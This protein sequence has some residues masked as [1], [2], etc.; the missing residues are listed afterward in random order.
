[1]RLY[2]SEFFL[3]KILCVFYETV[4]A[5]NLLFKNSKPLFGC[6]CENLRPPVSMFTSPE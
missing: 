5:E 4:I 1:M 3:E 2:N 6:N